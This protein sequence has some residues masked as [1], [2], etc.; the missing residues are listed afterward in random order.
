[1]ITLSTKE[2]MKTYFK[3]RK[4]AAD[5]G[6]DFL[7]K[8]PVTNNDLII[9][10]GEIDDEGYISWLPVEMTV[11][12]D[13]KKLEDEL[14]IKFHPS[15][16]E[17]F[18]SYWFADLDGFFKDYYICLESVLPDAEMVSFR[19]SVKGYKKNHEGCL[20]KVPIG[21]EGNGLI[22]VIE[23]SSGIVQLEDYERG[24]FSNIAS[25]IE[26]LIRNLR[27]KK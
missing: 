21:I 9:Y 23:N 4:E 26:E 10:E 2:A 12:Q 6:L 3:M 18:N 25:N 8:T 16:V 17:Y 20:E 19:E 7:W 5:K 22:I 11:I 1:M 24:T 27:L 14:N 15:L 13:F